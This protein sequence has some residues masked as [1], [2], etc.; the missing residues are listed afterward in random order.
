MGGLVQK[1]VTAPVAPSSGLL[2]G[3]SCSSS[4]ASDW[5]ELLQGAA[6]FLIGHSCSS[7]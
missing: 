7:S 6:E 2:I 1:P 5:P 3:E 4:R